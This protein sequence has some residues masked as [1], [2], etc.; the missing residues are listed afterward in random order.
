LTRTSAE[1]LGSVRRFA[2]IALRQVRRKD[3]L[4]RRLLLDPVAALRNETQIGVARSAE[5]RSDAYR[6]RRV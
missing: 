5:L 4:F 3:A 1:W 2:D 6:E